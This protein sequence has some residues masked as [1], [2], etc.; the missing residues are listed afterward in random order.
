MF[1]RLPPAYRHYSEVVAGSAAGSPE[2][3]SQGE[4]NI[5]SYADYP[6]TI[7]G[8]SDVLKRETQR[9]R[10]RDAYHAQSVD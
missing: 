7:G 3:G 9:E 6:P 1:L 5:R 8:H 2:E 10:C 4:S